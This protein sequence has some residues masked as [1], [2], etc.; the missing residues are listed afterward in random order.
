M[1]PFLALVLPL[2]LLFCGCGTESTP[3]Q[4]DVI[5]EIKKLGGKV[6]FNESGELVEVNFNRTQIT[7]AGLEHLN[8]KGLTSLTYLGLN[9]TQITDE[10]LEHLIGL[11]SLDRLYLSDTQITDAGLAELKAALPKCTVI[12]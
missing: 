5:A 9:H 10:G 7:D 11:T 2:A 6:R 3:Q 12:K 8:L 1:K 4:A